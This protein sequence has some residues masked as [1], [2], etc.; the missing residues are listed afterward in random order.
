[1]QTTLRLDDELYRQAKARAA[2]L[3]MSLTKFLE[4]AVRDRL[5][6]PVPAPRRRRLRLPVSTAAGGLAPGFSTLA[7][8][9]A[10]ADLAD[11]GLRAR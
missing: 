1:M 2:A 7:N 9:V 10:A 6:A 8:A 11:D 4:E 5:H 3:G